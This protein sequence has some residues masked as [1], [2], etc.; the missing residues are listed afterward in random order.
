MDDDKKWLEAAAGLEQDILYLKAALL[1]SKKQA[2]RGL[3]RDIKNLRMALAVYK[4]NA[5]AGVAWPSPDDLFCISA[6]PCGPQVATGTRRDF[7][8]AS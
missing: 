7:K 3:E 2:A 5:A 6:L 8:T 1:V 4:R